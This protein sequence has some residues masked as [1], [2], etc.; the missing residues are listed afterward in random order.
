MLMR[1]LARVEADGRLSIPD[2]I[3]RRLGLRAG[4]L[5]ELKV[6]G[7]SGK[8]RLLLSTRK[9]ISVTGRGR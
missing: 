7:G 5:V 3:R 2:N 4:H 6:V 9:S 8:K 1:A